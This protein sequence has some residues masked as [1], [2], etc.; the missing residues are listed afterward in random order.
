MAFVMRS[1]FIAETLRPATSAGF[2]GQRR[3]VQGGGRGDSAETGVLLGVEGG[4]VSKRRNS[5]TDE[6]TRKVA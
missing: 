5:L 3:V 2:C 6:R 4:Y 1:R